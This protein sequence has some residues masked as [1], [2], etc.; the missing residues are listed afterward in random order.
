[1]ARFGLVLQA[2][3]VALIEIP[4]N[5]VTWRQLRSSEQI[6]DRIEQLWSNTH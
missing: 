4:L 3:K 2:V 1:M 5:T 6:G